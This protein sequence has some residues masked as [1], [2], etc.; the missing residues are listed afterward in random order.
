M[1]EKDYDPYITKEFNVFA[2]QS[3]LQILKTNIVIDVSHPR[4]STQIQVI[5][6]ITETSLYNTIHSYTISFD[7]DQNGSNHGINVQKPQR[8]IKYST[9]KQILPHLDR[10]ES[11]LCIHQSSR[12]CGCINIKQQCASRT[13]CPCQSKC[14][15]WV[16][17]N[18]ECASISI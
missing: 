5:F 7:F 6:Y 3:E 11:L 15:R 17:I 13:A 1:R 2:T 4:R 12:I 14:I 16:R 9:R 8:K 10:V 18:N